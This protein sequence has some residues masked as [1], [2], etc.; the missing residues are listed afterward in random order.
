MRYMG[1]GLI[2]K[3]QKFIPSFTIDYQSDYRQKIAD[4]WPQSIDDTTARKEWGWK[5]SFD[6]Q[7]MTEDMLEKL[8][9]RY[10]KGNL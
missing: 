2:L 7:S 9:R 1:S 3:I 8:G 5:P 4:S 6:L 10:E